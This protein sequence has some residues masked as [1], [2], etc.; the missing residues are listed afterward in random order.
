MDSMGAF[1]RSVYLPLLVWKDHSRQLAY[2]SRYKRTQ[3]HSPERLAEH[4][5][6][7]L[8]RLIAHAMEHCAF[9]RRR[10]EEAGLDGPAEIRSLDDLRRLPTLP[11]ETVRERAEELIVPDPSGA[12]LREKRT[13]GSTGVPLRVQVNEDGMQHKTA[14]TWRHNGWAGYRAGDLAGVVWGDMGEPT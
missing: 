9:H 2:A 10:F 12:P 14:L 4:Q 11:K 8:K 6:Q 13:S 3:F 1:A 7:C 5:L